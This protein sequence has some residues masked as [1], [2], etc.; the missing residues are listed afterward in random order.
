M[1]I[2]INAA[3]APALEDADNFRGFKVVCTSARADCHDQFAIVG[4][5][6]GDHLWVKQDW[7]RQHGRQDPEWLAGL[8]KMLDYAGRAGW[9]DLAGAVR[10]HIEDS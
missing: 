5:L 10:A 3:T 6:D 7:L 4:R 8:G 1:I 9:M 2:Q